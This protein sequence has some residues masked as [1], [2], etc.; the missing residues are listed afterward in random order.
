MPRKR[1]RDEAELDA[2]LLQNEEP[3]DRGLLWKLRNMWQFANFLQYL[4]FFG[5]IVKID[6]SIDM[7]VCHSRLI[8]EP[9]IIS[10][11]C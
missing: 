2:S 5:K 8:L 3:K 11:H 1:A 9:L 6:E 7:D 4:Y 10:D